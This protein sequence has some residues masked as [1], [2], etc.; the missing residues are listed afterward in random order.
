[1]GLKQSQVL[2]LMLTVASMLT[3]SMANKNSTWNYGFNYTDWFGKHRN[4]TGGSNRIIVGGSANCQF[5]F[6]YTDWALKNGPFYLNDTLGKFLYM[7]M[8][9]VTAVMHGI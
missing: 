8:F 2:I 6:N 3:V 4:D 5:N 7:Y 9:L 1:M